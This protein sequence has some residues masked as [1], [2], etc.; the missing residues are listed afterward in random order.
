M[1]MT[2]HQ[3][4]TPRGQ[5]EVIA[6]AQRSKSVL[7]RVAPADAR[8][9]LRALDETSLYFAPANGGA[10]GAASYRRLAADIRAQMNSAHAA[11]RGD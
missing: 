4:Q 3:F 5:P 9:I 7:L 2:A 6:N 11:P 10:P 8:R 1:K